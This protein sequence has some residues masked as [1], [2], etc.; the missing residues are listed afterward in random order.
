MASIK[1]I[2]NLILYKPLLNGLVLIY[3]YFPLH[4][5]GIAI[6]ILTLIIKILLYPSSAKSIILQKKMAALQPKI[7]EL[8]EKFKNDR[9][10]QSIALMELYKKEKFSPFSG[11][12][13]SIIEGIIFISLFL[14]I[15]G[16]ISS[17]SLS[18]LYGFMPHNINLRLS[19]LGIMD[20]TKA[21]PY[22][23]FITGFFQFVQLKRSKEIAPQPSTSKKDM[24]EIFQKEM[25]YFFPI[26]TVIVL[27]TFPSA[28]GLYWVTITIFSVLQQELVFKKMQ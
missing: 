24:S 10:K 9:E 19:F 16:V 20:L 13:P 1:L 12:L 28:L 21:N 22:L 27:L 18:G 5:F 17:N 8:Q 2:F 4:D 15:K 6:I 25:L 26:F 7:K 11:C 3:L 14:V 23:A